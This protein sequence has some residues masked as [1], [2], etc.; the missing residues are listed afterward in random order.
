R[1][2]EKAGVLTTTVTLSARFW[3]GVKFGPQPIG[4][5]VALN[6]EGSS[7]LSVAV[8]RKEANETSTYAAKAIE[9]TN[10]AMNRSLWR[11]RISTYFA[12]KAPACCEQAPR[13]GGAS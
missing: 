13:Q 2:R 12:I 11:N 3:A 5:N 7:T 10:S 9:I 4:T 6:E 1:P 8:A